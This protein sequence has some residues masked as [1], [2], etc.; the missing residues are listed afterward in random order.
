MSTATISVAAALG[1][2]WAS[3]GGDVRSGHKRLVSKASQA[4]SG[5]SPGR[6]GSGGGGFG[7]EAGQRQGLA[8]HAQPQEEDCAIGG[9]ARSEGERVPGP[10]QGERPRCR[11]GRNSGRGGDE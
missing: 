7:G 8:A 10:A 4:F 9:E 2:C 11:G 1:A 3:S 6:K 5:R